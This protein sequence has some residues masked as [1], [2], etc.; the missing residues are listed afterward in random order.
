[1]PTGK[2]SPKKKIVKSASAVKPVK[3]TATA[4]KPPAK[5]APGR[6]SKAPSKPAKTLDREKPL[7]PTVSKSAAKGKAKAEVKPV[8]VKK[9]AP[10]ANAEISCVEECC[11]AQSGGQQSFKSEERS[12]RKNS[13]CFS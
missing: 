12:R 5:A 11:S 1:M 3:K 6:N 10:L 13:R 4:S 9:A 7:K 8:V 2:A